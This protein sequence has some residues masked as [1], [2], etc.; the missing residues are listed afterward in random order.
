[1]T[2]QLANKRMKLTVA[3]RARSLSAERKERL[4]GAA[5]LGTLA[6]PRAACGVSDE[7]LEY[8]HVI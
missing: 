5:A 4:M 7:H 8:R 3:C 2:K 1:M 6:V